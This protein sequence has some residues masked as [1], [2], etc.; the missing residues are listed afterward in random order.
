MNFREFVAESTANSPEGIISLAVYY[1]LT[2]AGEETVDGSEVNDFLSIHQYSIG[3]SAISTKLAQLSNKGLLKKIERKSAPSGYIMTPEGMADFEELSPHP[4]ETDVMERPNRKSTGTGQ[5]NSSERDAFV[6]YSGADWEDF[7]QPLIRRLEKLGLEI[8]HADFEITIGDSIPNSIE[9]GITKSDYGILV[10]SESYFEREWP[11]EELDALLQEDVTGEEKVILP[12]AYNIEPEDIKQHHKLL[13]KRYIVEGNRNNIDQVASSIFKAVR[14]GQREKITSE[15]VDE[16]SGESLDHFAKV[17]S[18][19]FEGDELNRF[20]NRIG[21]DIEW[22]DETEGKIREYLG[23]NPTAANTKGLSV[24]RKRR[25]TVENKINNLNNPDE[26]ILVIEKMA[27]PETHI[28]KNERRAKTI[29]SL[30]EA[31]I[32]E[33]LILDS[34]GEIFKTI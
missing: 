17:I 2:H 18:N 22:S 14:G 34:N 29:E 6:S 12:V 13:S 23:I 28:G 31:L 11:R 27:S 24:E 7:V 3:R 21:F 19:V 30:N 20:F 1:L 32:H 8:W 16:F 26:V 10:L 4:S 33:G 15:N 25:L 5:E 9:N